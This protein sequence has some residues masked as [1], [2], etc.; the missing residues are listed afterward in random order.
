MKL[1]QCLASLTAIVSILLIHADSRAAPPTDVVIDLFQTPQT[2]SNA[3]GDRNTADGPD[4]IGG[5]RDLLTFVLMSVSGVVPGQ[6]YIESAG[7]GGG[8][9]YYDGNDN[10]PSFSSPGGMGSIDLTQGGRND[11]LRFEFTSASNIPATLLIDVKN[12]GIGSTLQVNLPQSAGIFDIPFSS[13]SNPAVFSTVG[14]INLHFEIHGTG[15]YTIDDIL[16]VPEPCVP[17]LLL[18]AMLALG[19]VRARSRFGCHT[20]R[21]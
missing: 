1:I 16:A 13:F 5:E 20:N 7:G 12:F 11:R 14:M 10:D 18:P 3:I 15:T 8:D 6:L 19:L 9:I 2:A 4:I 17:A 21:R